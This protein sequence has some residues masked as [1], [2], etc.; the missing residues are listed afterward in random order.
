MEGVGWLGS[1][2]KEGNCKIECPERKGYDSREG[3]VWSCSLAILVNG[4]E[5]VLSVEQMMLQPLSVLFDAAPL[6]LDS[7]SGRASCLRRNILCWAFF[8][9]DHFNFSHET[10][11]QSC[12]AGFVKKLSVLSAPFKLKF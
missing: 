9:V 4:W 6:R 7:G 3:G 11:I 2:V 5:S 10:R 12:G 8:G 1:A